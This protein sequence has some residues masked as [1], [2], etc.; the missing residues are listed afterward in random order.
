MRAIGMSMSSKEH[1][2][3]APATLGYQSPPTA[4]LKIFQYFESDKTSCASFFSTVM[5]EFASF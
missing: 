2:V 3:P 4:I 5:S 1:F